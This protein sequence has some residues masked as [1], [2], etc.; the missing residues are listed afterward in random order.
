MRR[1]QLINNARQEGMVELFSGPGMGSGQILPFNLHKVFQRG[2]H[3]RLDFVIVEK[4]SALP[5]CDIFSLRIE[6]RQLG[7]K[8]DD[9]GW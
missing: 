5:S 9:Y 6:L 4:L 2:E 8:V 3:N 1:A 7:I